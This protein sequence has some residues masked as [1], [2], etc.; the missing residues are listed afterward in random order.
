MSSDDLAGLRAV[1]WRS[2]TGME[3]AAGEY[4]YT[5][6]YVRNM[7]QSQAVDV[8]QADVTRCG[9]ITAFLQIAALCEAFHTDLSGHCAPALHLHAACASPRLRHL[10]W[11]HDHARIERMLFDAC[12]CP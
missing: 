10:E 7:L 6:D 4:A 11:F 2:P 1:R 3:I 5:V 8:Q 9:G 12:P